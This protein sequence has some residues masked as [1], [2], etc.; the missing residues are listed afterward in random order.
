MRVT[1]TPTLTET[2]R[3]QRL[4]WQG[5]TAR[6]IPIGP[7]VPISSNAPGITHRVRVRYRALPVVIEE[8]L[9]ALA[10]DPLAPAAI[11]Q[12]EAVHLEMEALSPR[13]VPGG[14]NTEELGYVCDPPP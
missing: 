14:E 4:A 8:E 6:L 9:M 2:S 1:Q 12:R 3:C 10:E 5:S 11:K 7:E 13:G